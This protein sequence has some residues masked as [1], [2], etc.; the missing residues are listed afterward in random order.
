M[1][2]PQKPLNP[3]K[4]GFFL[5]Q[6]NFVFYE[7]EEEEEEYEAEEDDQ[8]DFETLLMDAEDDPVA[9]IA[10]SQMLQRKL[11]TIFSTRKNTEV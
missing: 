10:T 1:R 2:H 8:P 7:E 4:K 9:L 11:Y 3:I 6:E 5:N